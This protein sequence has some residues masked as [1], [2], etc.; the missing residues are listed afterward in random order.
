M[1]R[2]KCVKPFEIRAVDDDGRDE[3]PERETEVPAGRIYVCKGDAYVIDI[4]GVHLE[5][6]DYTWIEI[7][8]DM[9]EEYF[10]AI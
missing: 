7:T 1:Q 10:E 6:D 5:A 9:L 2:Y 8:R 4:D 3:E